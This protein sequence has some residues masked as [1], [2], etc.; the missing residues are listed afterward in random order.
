MSFKQNKLKKMKKFEKKVA[1]V[2]GGGSG[3][4]SYRKIRNFRR[5]G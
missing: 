2:T 1:I 3:T 5:S 4:A